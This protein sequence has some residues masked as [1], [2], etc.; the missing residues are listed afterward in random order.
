MIEPTQLRDLEPLSDLPESLFLLKKSSSSST[1]SIEVDF[2]PLRSKGESACSPLRTL[3]VF[4]SD[5]NYFTPSFILEVD[6][7]GPLLFRSATSKI[8]RFTKTCIIES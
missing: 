3:P 8:W 7:V 5:K 1:V 4:H 2:S 6:Q